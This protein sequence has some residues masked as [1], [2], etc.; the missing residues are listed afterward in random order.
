MAG[1][2]SNRPYLKW[3]CQLHCIL[4]YITTSKCMKTEV[5]VGKGEVITDIPCVL[6]ELIILVIYF[7]KS[8]LSVVRLMGVLSPSGNNV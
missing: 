2:R 3:L 4:R 8:F 7:I 6:I 1:Y 5:K